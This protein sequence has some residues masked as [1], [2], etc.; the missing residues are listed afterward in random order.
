MSLIQ[1]LLF[2]CHGTLPYYAKPLLLLVYA[3]YKQE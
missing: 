2:L 3:V 1:P